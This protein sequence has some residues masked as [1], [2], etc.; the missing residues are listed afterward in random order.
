MLHEHDRVAAARQVVEH[1]DETLH[2]GPVQPDRGLVEHVQRRAGAL[3]GELARD[4]EPLRLAAGQL[5]R[6]LPQTQVAEPHLAQHVQRTD[7]ARLLVEVLERR[8]HGHVER[9]AD[10]HAAH[11]HV[12]HLGLEARARADLARHHEVGE[13]VHLDRHPA[14]ALAVLA[15]ATGGIERERAILEAARHRRGLPRERLAQRGVGAHVGDRAT[16]RGAADGRLV[17]EHDALHGLEPLHRAMRADRLLLAPLVPLER[18]AIQDV[19]DEAALARTRHAGHRGEPTERE[20]RRDALEVVL[21]G[22]LDRHEAR[23]RSGDRGARDPARA[24]QIGRGHRLGRVG[25]PR[26]RPSVEQLPAML[27]RP[28]PEIGEVLG[29]GDHERVMLDHDQRV[30]ARGELVQDADEALGVARMQSGRRL[31][32]H[33]ERVGEVGAERVGQFDPLRLPA[34]ERARQAVER[35]IAEVH[36]Q[37]EREPRAQFGQ[38]DPGHRLLRRREREAFQ[39]RRGLAHRQGAQRGDVLA[40]D[41]HAQRLGAQARARAFAAAPRHLIAL[42]DEAV[43]GLVCLL[44]QALEERDHA[45]ELL[46]PLEQD[47]AMLRVERVPRFIEIETQLV[48]EFGDLGERHRAPRTGPRCQR[49]LAQ[50]L[51][52]VRHDEL[53]REREHVAE[54][55]AP[56]ADAER[57]VEREQARFGTHRGATAVRALPALAAGLGLGV[58]DHQLQTALAATERLLARLDE[59][60]ALVGRPAH[61]IHHDVDLLR[62]LAQLRDR[63]ERDGLPADPRTRVARAQQMAGLLVPR[64]PARQHDRRQHE[65]DRVQRPGLRL[66]RDGPRRIRDHWTVA[67]TAVHRPEAGVEQPEVIV[68]LG[69]GADG[70][71]GA[72]GGRALLDAHRRGQAGDRVHLG[73]RQPIEELLRVGAHRLDVATLPLGIE[74]VERERGLARTRDAGHHR[75]RTTRQVEVHAAQVV[76]AGASDADRGDGLGRGHGGGGVPRE[77][78]GLRDAARLGGDHPVRSHAAAD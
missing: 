26:G 42:H 31:V 48:G 61:A 21:R 4:L 27:P 7:E 41:A 38:R 56:C 6:G 35:Q 32:E 19:L 23:R 50:A 64:Q 43:R 51:A 28:G 69:G 14:G 11:A 34:R 45:A 20:A 57:A 49:A 33:V 71:T 58:A 18:G 8:V 52:T 70:R 39:E 66:P 3:L 24:T 74:G 2:I 37:Q 47:L 10:V 77:T 40:A 22:A 12:E 5:V 78:A 73:A 55:L 67:V 36:A 17:D 65:H 15:P 13:E 59:S 25:D 30:R 68:D 44:L 53:G 29:R 62:A 72:A 60:L 75:E 63:I 1:L 54:A 46:V 76:L 16:A 9:L